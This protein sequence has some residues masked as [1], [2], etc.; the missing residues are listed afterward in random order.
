M[1]YTDM[2]R[3]LRATKQINA[4]LVKLATKDVEQIIKD[5]MDKHVC[6]KSTQCMSSEEVYNHVVKE[7]G[8]DLRLRIRSMVADLQRADITDEVNFPVLVKELRLQR[9]RYNVTRMLVLCD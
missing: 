9:A 1:S 2:S 3:A 5:H 4:D 7:L 8:R 6:S